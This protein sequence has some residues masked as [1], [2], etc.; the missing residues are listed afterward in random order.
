MRWWERCGGAGD[1]VERSKS[2][3]VCVERQVLD[4]KKGHILAVRYVMEH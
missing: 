4:I 3:D 2:N 1:V